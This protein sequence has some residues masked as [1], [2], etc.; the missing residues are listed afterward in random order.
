MPIEISG[1]SVLVLEDS[2]VWRH[3]ER[4]ALVAPQ[5]PGLWPAVWGGLALCGPGSV[6][7]RTLGHMAQSLGPGSSPGCNCIGCPFKAVY[8][9]S[10]SRVSALASA[11]TRT[12]SSS[13]RRPSVQ[14]HEGERCRAVRPEC[15][16]RAHSVLEGR[17]GGGAG[18]RDRVRQPTGHARGYPLAGRQAE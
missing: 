6:S 13:T 1:M 7:T 4:A 10:R 5:L 15:K 17:A 9:R 16:T 18:G 8:L 3:V 11:E 14:W 2:Q 12:S